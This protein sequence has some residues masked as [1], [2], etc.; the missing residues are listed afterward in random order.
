[1]VIRPGQRF[2]TRGNPQGVIAAP[3]GAYCLD[4]VTGAAYKKMAGQGPTG[5]YL[6][7]EMTNFRWHNW[8]ALEDTGTSSG[9][10]GIPK[11][12]GS[13][14]PTFNAACAFSIAQ[15]VGRQYSGGYTLNA[16]GD[17]G[18]WRLTSLQQSGPKIMQGADYATL[19]PYIDAFWDILTTPR[20]TAASVST[21]LTSVRI[22]IGFI[23]SGATIVTN[24]T[25]A[26]SDAI[27]T[28]FAPGW[29]LGAGQFGVA[30]R[31]STAAADPG[32]VGVCGNDNG[33]AR[34]QTVSGLVNAIA[35]NTLYRIRIRFVPNGA[36]LLPAIPRVF[37]SVNDGPEVVV[38]AN[39]GPGSG[40]VTNDRFYQPFCFIECLEAVNRKSLALHQ[41]F[42][43]WG[44]AL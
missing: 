18:G 1:M 23:G 33:A 5:W 36:P 12:A 38:A 14:D 32:W 27:G 10:I 15:P 35:V 43:T 21:D 22:W 24:A 13:W 17:K 29:G 16:V 20:P 42:A 6:V 34:V 39:V 30:M 28:A 44:A 40:F 25:L 3:Q 8:N 37:F 2:V 41:Y 11:G 26:S 7:P 9:L 31:F 19:D 4:E